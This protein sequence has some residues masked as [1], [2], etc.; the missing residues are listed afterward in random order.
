MSKQDI[1]AKHIKAWKVSGLSKSAYCRQHEIALHNLH[2][3][4]KRLASNLEPKL[5]PVI[6]PARANG[7]ATLRIG[8]Q[9]V[10]EATPQ[11]LVDILA[12]LNERGLFHVAP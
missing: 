4:E 1:W 8:Q 12:S 6:T 11:A 10:I 5:I 2:Y 3:W 9:V 7:V